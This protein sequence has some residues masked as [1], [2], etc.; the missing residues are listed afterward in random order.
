MQPEKKTLKMAGNDYHAHEKSGNKAPNS[1]EVLNIVMKGHPV[2]E[3][4]LTTMSDFT[5]SVQLLHE[6]REFSELAKNVG[7]ELS[8]GCHVATEKDKPY[9]RYNI[10]KSCVPLSRPYKMKCDVPKCIN[11]AVMQKYLNIHV[12]VKNVNVTEDVLPVIKSRISN[13]LYKSCSK[14]NLCFKHFEKNFIEDCPHCAKAFG[15][16]A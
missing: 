12:T 4:K 8:C 16:S 1:G 13:S 3:R 11:L 9:I 7:M 15:L 10:P 6:A 5:K 14:V 2:R